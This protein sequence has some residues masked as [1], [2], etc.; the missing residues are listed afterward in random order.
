M[1]NEE[2]ATLVKYGKLHRN[3]VYIFMADGIE[4]SGMFIEAMAMI[5][6]ENNKYDCIEIKIGFRVNFIPI[7]KIRGV[8]NSAGEIIYKVSK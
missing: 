5:D 1:N 7:S 8:K 2:L 6:H 3:E 4:Y